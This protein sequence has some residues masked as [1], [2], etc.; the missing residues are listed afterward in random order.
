MADVL[1]V[2]RNPR[3][4]HH[5]DFPDVAVAPNGDVL[6]LLRRC[7][8]WAHEA[9]FRFG[10][11]LTFFETH[12]E[13]LL[14]RSRDAGR[15]FAIERVLHTGLAYDPMVC[16]LPDGALMAGVV[17]GQAGSRKERA[18]LN[19]VL[20]RHLP[21]LD[22]VITVQGIGV[23]LSHGG[24]DTW[25]LEPQVV[26][27]PGWENVYNLRKPFPLADGTILLPVAVGYPWRSRYVGLLRSWDGGLTWSD[28]SFVAEDP[29][30]RAHYGAGT[31]YW[32]P[33]MAATPEGDLVC[34]CVLD[35]RDSAPQR[36]PGAAETGRAFAPAAALPALYRTHSQDSGFTWSVP[37]PTGL[38]GD[39]P[40]VVR[41]PDGR[42]LL[43]HTQRHTD[44]SAVLA[45]TSA[46]GGVTW[47]QAAVLR[48][49]A[50]GAFYY[51]NTA[52]LPDGAL[53]TVYMASGP[54]KVR[55]VEGAR[56]RLS[57]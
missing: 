32:Q 22:T 21:Q 41:L 12:A 39:F 10:R 4:G 31:G 50:D 56:W 36:T 18:R 24:G 40:S 47:T 46:D 48:E 37:Q 23:W 30:G 27:L 13:I 35:D 53:L 34:V 54:D 42:L 25:A 14:L 2:Y 6:V 43:T 29:A 38:A 16:A 45:H 5:A 19:G 55:Y 11:P 8:A 9:T 28:P 57:C 44:G 1:V 7:G 33:A 52:I 51:P 15:G 26:S 49:A 3:A 17:V 20:H